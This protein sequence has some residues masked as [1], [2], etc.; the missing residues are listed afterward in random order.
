MRRRGL[1]ASLA[2]C[3]RVSV[4]EACKHGAPEAR[5]RSGEAGSAEPGSQGG[6]RARGAG[7]REVGEPGRAAGRPGP[8]NRRRGG[9]GTGAG[10]REAGPAVAGRPGDRS[11]PAPR[12]PWPGGGGGGGKEAARA[13]G[14]ARRGRAGRGG[15]E[16]RS[17]MVGDTR[18]RW[19]GGGG[20]AGGVSEAGCLWSSGPAAASRAAGVTAARPPQTAPSGRR[21]FVCVGQGPAGL[22]GFGCA[23]RL[24]PAGEGRPCRRRRPRRSRTARGLHGPRSRG[25]A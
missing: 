7:G 1:S 16:D 23:P 13:A 10:G 2:G 3:S 22:R 4:V 6:G 21:S 8:R 17:I 18:P 14:R 19:R 12:R 5:S 9:R 24:R 11:P 15:G 25:V 20:G